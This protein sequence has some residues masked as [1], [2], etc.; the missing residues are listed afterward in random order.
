MFFVV[1][2]QWKEIEYLTILVKSMLLEDCL[3]ILE[4]CLSETKKKLI[5]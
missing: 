4:C 3:P 2:E 5:C 1:L